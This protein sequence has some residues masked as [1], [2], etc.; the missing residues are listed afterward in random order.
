MSSGG[1]GGTFGGRGGDGK[2]IDGVGG[3]AVAGTT[4]FPTKLRGGCK[5]GAGAGGPP[6][7]G[8]ARPAVDRTISA[9][10]AAIHLR[11]DE[12]ADDT[13]GTGMA[14]GRGIDRPASG[15]D[16]DAHAFVIGMEICIHNRT[17]AIASSATPAEQLNAN[18]FVCR[19]TGP[20]DQLQCDPDTTAREVTA[21]LV[22]ARECTDTIGQPWPKASGRLRSRAPVI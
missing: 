11:R 15:Q 17:L 13:G 3:I 20:A 4:M 22:R 19:S 21:H 7:V 9:T 14:G 18:A 6:A 1:S 12:A 10:S 5:G 8:R 16:R 2:T